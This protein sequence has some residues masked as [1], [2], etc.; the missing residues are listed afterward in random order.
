MYNNNNLTN[1]SAQGLCCCLIFGFLSSF[2]SLSLSP[3]LSLYLHP[4]PHHC[5]P[6]ITVLVD[7]A[8]R[9]LLQPHLLCLCL[10]SFGKLFIPYPV[11]L[12][13]LLLVSRSLRT[14]YCGHRND[15]PL[16][17]EPRVVNGCPFKT[18][19]RNDYSRCMLLPL[20]GISSRL[21]STFQVH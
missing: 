8:S 16:C 1:G 20:L 15:G 13:S 3:S 7:W 12:Q 21:I 9:Y 14:G 17:G 2:A 10:Q 4:A 19:S 11:C 18:W 5:R 6:D